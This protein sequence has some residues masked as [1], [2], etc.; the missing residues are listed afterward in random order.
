LFPV[1]AKDIEKER[2]RWREGE[3]QQERRKV[4]KIKRKNANTTEKRENREKKNKIG[5]KQK[6]KQNQDCLF[7]CKNYFYLA[8]VFPFSRKSDMRT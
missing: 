2:R 6:G 8:V 5:R 3:S 1:S 4:N 7:F